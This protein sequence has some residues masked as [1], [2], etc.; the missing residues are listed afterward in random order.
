MNCNEKQSDMKNIIMLTNSHN[1]TNKQTQRGKLRNQPSLIS[2]HMRIFGLAN[3]PFLQITRS[4]FVVKA[5]KAKLMDKASISAILRLR[6]PLDQEGLSF[7]LHKLNVIRNECNPKLDGIRNFR[8]QRE[9][10]FGLPP[11]LL[12]NCS[13]LVR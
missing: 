7:W 2:F 4:Q 3:H 8:C 13:A 10:V 11:E 9:C 5:F 1:K 12:L 6:A